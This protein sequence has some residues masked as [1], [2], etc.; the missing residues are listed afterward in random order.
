MP[1]L[2][3]R[4][5]SDAV[6]GVSSRDYDLLDRAQVDLMLCE[7]QPEVLVHLAAYCGGLGAN[8][9]NPADF[10]FRNTLLIAHVFQAAAEHR[11]K[12]LIYTMGGCSYPVDASSPIDEGQMWQGLP[13]GDSLAYSAAKKMG[14]IAS[15]AY[16]HQYGLRSAVLVPGNMYGPHDNFRTAESHVIA[17]MVRRLYEAR[18]EQKEEVVMWGSGLALRDFVYAG[19]VAATLPYFIEHNDVPGPI[20]IGSGTAT[21]IRELAAAIA[22]VVG[23][24]GRI[25]WDISKPD[26][27]MEKLF[28]VR[29]L[30]RLGLAC[31]TSLCDGLQKTVDWF[32]EH[33]AKRSDGIRL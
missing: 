25:T 28:D 2:K 32:V 29:R 21:S 18:V 14:L 24:E 17:A 1:I 23:Y 30:E 16:A 33:Y 7:H 31:P 4:Y 12:K 10:Y 26:G 6:V 5:G 19:D 22:A 13:H 11:V 9:A 27:Q 3:G 15:A 8:R 20:N